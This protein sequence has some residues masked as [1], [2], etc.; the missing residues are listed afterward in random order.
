MTKHLNKK[1]NL[2]A[3]GSLDINCAYLMHTTHFTF[4]KIAY[5]HVC[6]VTVVANIS[7][8]EHHLKNYHMG[9]K[10]R[11]PNFKLGLYE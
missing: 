2:T 11:K 8:G 10:N 4:K 5:N 7:R 1:E 3:V 6:P 9:G